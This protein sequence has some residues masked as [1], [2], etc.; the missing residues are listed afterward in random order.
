MARLDCSKQSFKFRYR[1]IEPPSHSICSY[2]VCSLACGPNPHEIII[3][4]VRSRSRDCNI[5]V[6]VPPC[7]A[8]CTQSCAL[9]CLAL[10]SVASMSWRRGEAFFRLFHYRRRCR[11]ASSCQNVIQLHPHNPSHFQVVPRLTLP[12]SSQCH[13][14]AHLKPVYAHPRLKQ[15]PH[16]QLLRPKQRQRHLLR[17]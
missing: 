17:P 16:P 9:A 13:P 10:L 5:G 7:S 8:T 15:S 1:S 14:Q 4:V 3:A 6:G 12:T 2:P 11:R